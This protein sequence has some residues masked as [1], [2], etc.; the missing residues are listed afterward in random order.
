M[1]DLEE[2]RERLLQEVKCLDVKLRS[3]NEQMESM[4]VKANVLCMINVPLEASL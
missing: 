4:K 3:S 2:E 1:R